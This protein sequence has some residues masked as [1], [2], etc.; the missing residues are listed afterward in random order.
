MFSRACS[1]RIVWMALKNG[2]TR[3]SS[4]A[5]P[6]IALFNDQRFITSM[7]YRIVQR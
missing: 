2:L 3:K 7:V 5:S 1:L 4:S 6:P